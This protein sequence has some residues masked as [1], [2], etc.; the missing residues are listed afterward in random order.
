MGGVNPVSNGAGLGAI[1]ED[2]ED[3]GSE[4][5]DY[6]DEYYDGFPAPGQ[7]A[8][9]S[10]LVPQAFSHF[11]WVVTNGKKLVCDLQVGDHVVCCRCTH[12]ML[13]TWRA[14]VV[15]GRHVHELALLTSGWHALTTAPSRRRSQPDKLCMPKE[16]ASRQLSVTP[17]RLMGL[18]TCCVCASM[19]MA[20]LSGCAQQH[21]RLHA[22]RPRHPQPHWQPSLRGHR[23][24]QERH[25]SLLFYTHM[26]Q[27]V[28]AAG[29]GHAGPRVVSIIG[30]AMLLVA[31][32]FWLHVMNKPGLTRC[33]NLM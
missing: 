2:E 13:L 19:Q 20:A 1:A 12:A 32:Q 3:Y 16:L 7:Q 6:F 17:L 14:Q 30:H 26:Q 18:T 24:G 25:A 15:C 28:P 33:C 22:D 8:A 4:E 27:A 9:L 31:H 21:G 29:A 10:D 11:T 23:Q 5:E